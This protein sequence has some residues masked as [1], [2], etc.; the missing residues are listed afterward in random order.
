MIQVMWIRQS[1]ELGSTQ[2]ILVIIT[3][4]ETDIELV[5]PSDLRVRNK[6]RWG[7]RQ[8]RRS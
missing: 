2:S 1:L 3:G 8:R 4:R 7:E 6:G 5:M